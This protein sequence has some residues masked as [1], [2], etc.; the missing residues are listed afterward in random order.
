MLLPTSKQR[1]ALA[2]SPPAFTAVD[3]FPSANLGFSVLLLLGYHSFETC[4]PDLNF[5]R[6]LSAD[7]TFPILSLLM[8]L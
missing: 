6:L 4:F 3:S 2:L 1:S 7:L 8:G 5:W